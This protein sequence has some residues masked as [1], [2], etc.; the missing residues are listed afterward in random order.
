VPG[1]GPALKATLADF[2]RHIDGEVKR[3]TDLATAA[4]IRQ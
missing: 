4:D 3:A 2:A 1:R